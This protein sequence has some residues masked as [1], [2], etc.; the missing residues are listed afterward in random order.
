MLKTRDLYAAGDVQLSL[1]AA[2]AAGLAFATALIAIA[3]LMA[4]LRRATFT[5]FVVYRVVLGA[6]LLAVAYGFP[7]G[8]L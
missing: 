5:P 8:F 1:D 4:W 3:A 6:A 7:G 2:L